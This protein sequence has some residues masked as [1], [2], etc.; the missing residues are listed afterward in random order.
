MISTRVS[1]LSLPIL[2]G[3]VLSLTSGCGTPYYVEG[4]NELGDVPDS[5]RIRLETEEQEERIRREGVREDEGVLVRELGEERALTPLPL[6]YSA[7]GPYLLRR[8]DKVEIDVLFYPELKSVSLVRS[9]GMITAPGVGDVLALGRRP[10]EVAADIEAYYSTILRDPTTTLNVLAF[11]ERRAYVF[12]EVYRPGALDL[13]QRMTM[14]Q[15]LAA[16]GSPKEDAK[17]ATVVLLRRKSET[18]ARAYRLDLRGVL[19]GESLAADILLQ[20]DDVVYVPRTFVANMERFVEAVFR[21]LTPVPDM[22]IRS[23]DAIH[24]NKRTAIRRDSDEPTT[25]LTTE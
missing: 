16:A 24:V 12:G 8:N 11:G 2:C 17:L 9:D 13:R 22:F 23:Y 20:P 1:L 14:S 19:A 6:E 25:I 21:G 4:Q 7:E 15:A 10:T 3:F 5:L 18:S